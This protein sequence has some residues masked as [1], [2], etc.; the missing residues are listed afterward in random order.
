MK[1]KK[2]ENRTLYRILNAIVIVAVSGATLYCVTKFLHLS[3]DQFNNAAQIEEYIVP[4]N[5]RVSAYVD[6][7]N[8]SEHQTVHLGDTLIILDDRELQIAYRRAKAELLNA[9]AAKESKIASLKTA[10][11]NIEVASSS[12]DN[13]RVKLEYALSNYRRYEALFDDEAVTQQQFEDIKTQYRAQKAIYDQLIKQQ[14]STSFSAN[15]VSVS[16]KLEDSKIEAAQAAL[17]MAKLNL[18]YTVIRAPFNGTMGRRQVND[19]QLIQAGQQL[20]A[21]VQNNTKWVTA[22]YL[23][24]EMES[25]KIGELMN[26]S[27]DA[28]GGK[29]LE[30]KIVAI[31]GATGARYSAIPTDNSAG[32]FI[33]VQQRIPVRL[34]FTKANKKSDL[35]KLKAGMNVVITKKT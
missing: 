29:I 12:I 25:I 15:E 11:N 10:N 16:L 21:L 13:A 34:E 31:S 18:L 20:A 30:A 7:I 26:V 1:K 33:K 17:Q 14:T 4:I 9:Q 27:V 32:N 22:N 3:D 5:S 8:F 6:K 2:N 23:E 28:L 19:G 24:K 35:G